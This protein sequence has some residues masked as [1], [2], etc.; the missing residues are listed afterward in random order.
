M[1]S[2]LSKASNFDTG[3][4]CISCPVGSVITSCPGRFVLSDN[5]FSRPIKL[6]PSITDDVT[7]S[8]GE[9]APNM[10]RTLGIRD[11]PLQAGYHL[12]VPMPPEEEF[13]HRQNEDWPS[14]T[15]PWFTVFE[16]VDRFPDSLDA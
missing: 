11:N 8:G 7:M 3:E 16:Y 1:L 2:D 9:K 14:S 12:N 4:N 6:V 13:D 5:A 15:P 10:F